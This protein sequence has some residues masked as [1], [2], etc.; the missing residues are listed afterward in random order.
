MR[1]RIFRLKK[2]CLIKERF[3]NMEQKTKKTTWFPFL[4]LTAV[5]LLCCAFH[6]SL[7]F[8]GES[9][10]LNLLKAPIPFDFFGGKITYSV[11]YGI[12]YLSSLLFTAFKPRLLSISAI[13]LLLF[14]SIMIFLP[15]S[16][17]A[18]QF[19]SRHAGYYLSSLFSDRLSLTLKSLAVILFGVIFLIGA[20]VKKKNRL[21]LGGFGILIAIL[22]LSAES[23]YLLNPSVNAETL[24]FWIK[25]PFSLIFDLFR[26]IP[27][28]LLPFLCFFSPAETKQLPIE[29]ENN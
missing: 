28:V 15:A 13:S 11:F 25:F 23:V 16:Y 9:K 17:Y 2:S 24:S 8:Q 29:K 27:F 6:F 10:L 18:E 1:F 26:L 7:L 14:E 5:I 21:V 19:N 12:F 22:L 4:A 20:F 3:I